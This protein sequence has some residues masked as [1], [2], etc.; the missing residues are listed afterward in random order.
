MKIKPTYHR[1]IC[2][3]ILTIG[4]SVFAL[5]CCAFADVPWPVIPGQ[6][7]NVLNYGAVGDGTTDNAAAIQSAINAA[8]QAGGGTVEIPSP[9]TYECG[10]LNLSNS[11]NLQVDAG[12]ELQMLPISK[13][14]SAS[15]PFI[16]G[17]SLHDVEFSGTGTIDGNGSGWWSPLA[18]SRPDFINFTKTTR[19]GFRDLSLQN[20]PTFHLMLKG[21]NANITITNININTPGTSPNTDGMDLASTNIL[22]IN[23]YISDGDD[24][25]EI[26]G[27]Q[28]CA[29]ITV[30]NCQFGTGHGVSIGSYTSGGVSNLFVSGCSFNGTANGIRIKSDNDR[31]GVVQ[32]L[33]YQ[34]LTMTNV[35]FPIVIYEY[36]NS[37]G[38]P[39]NIWPATAAG[40][41]VA[42][43]SSTTP[44]Y[45][46]IIISN[47]TANA[48]S[49]YPAC[50]IW[51]RTE[52]PITNV[53][54]SKI[55]ISATRPCEIYNAFQV[56]CVDCSF[57]LPARTNTYEFF[58]TETTI[59][60]SVVSSTPLTLDGLCNNSYRD[61]LSLYNAKAVM[62]NTN[63]ISINPT[64]LI[65]GT[66]VAI[67]N[68]LLLGSSSDVTFGCGLNAATMNVTG[69]LTAGGTINIE[70]A[71][72]FGAGTYTLFTYAGTL[73]WNAPVLGNTPAG[74]ACQ[75]STSSAGQVNLVV[76][77]SGGNLPAAPT[78]LSAAGGNLLVNLNWIQSTSSGIT[79]NNIYRST[80]GSGGPYN[81]LAN[82]A[83]ATSYSDTAVSAGNTYYYSVTAV[84]A[85]GESAMSAYAGATTVPPP[86]SGLTAAAG[87]SQVALNWNTAAG[88]SSYNVKRSTASGG[89]YTTIGT[90]T[91]GS[92][93]DT[94][95]ANGTTYYYV[96]SAVN[97]SGESA[98][99]AEVSATPQA[100]TAPAAPTN[101]V[102]T[103]GHRK[104]TLTWTQS[105]SS[106]ITT[107]NVYRATTST[108]SYS[109]IASI[110]ATTSYS[111]SG[112]TT[113]KTYYYVVTAVNGSGLE[114]PYSNQAT[115]TVQ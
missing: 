22:V 52:L 49:S 115:A 108:G 97:S 53:V 59:S 7:F 102:A 39:N 18:S 87:D 34:N 68:N 15:T 99:S 65:S 112:L 45:R 37:V 107:N 94:T 79:G 101:L 90:A 29:Y 42:S 106:N 81:L 85:N 55:N 89:P 27:S 109:R 61:T 75:L 31:G 12:A 6:T 28:L 26:G 114:S 96:V 95:A 36:Y 8:A 4:C 35:N 23:S 100:A 16:N 40:E 71:G 98:N 69:N 50:L 11:I 62:N 63:T 111:N 43:V 67:T 113:G 76:T 13:W 20:P 1:S 51:G 24:N 73:T 48:A 92:F 47:V 17:T 14:P 78:G 88:A 91:T 58:D 72:G 21:N 46:D 66:T 80:S 70:D 93:T 57:S 104:I 84:N 25:I 9:G 82:L 10:P 2:F 44:V 64:L 86:P 33:V 19:I 38:T 83:A 54:L 60:N 56:Q 74:F 110:P 77:T 3:R 105:T 5:C 30:T 103:P 32:N 41:T